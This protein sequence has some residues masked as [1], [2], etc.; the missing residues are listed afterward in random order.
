[1]ILNLSVANTEVVCR[2]G[3]PVARGTVDIVHSQGS[4]TLSERYSVAPVTHAMNG[5]NGPQNDNS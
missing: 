4:A 3:S 1:M 5:N 2:S